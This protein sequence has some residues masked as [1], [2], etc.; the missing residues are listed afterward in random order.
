[1]RCRAV[2]HRLHAFPQLV[3]KAPDNYEFLRVQIDNKEV[4]SYLSHING[5]LTDIIEVTVED[6][7]Y[8]NAIKP[9]ETLKSQAITLTTISAVAGVA[10]SVLF[11]YLFISRQRETAQI[12]MMMG[13]GRPK[14]VS[15]LLYGILLVALIAT[16]VGSLIAG[17]FDVRVTDTVWQALQDAPGLDER[18]SERALGI[19]TTFVPE[20]ATAAWVRWSSAGALILIILIITI[21]FALTTLRKPKRKKIKEF[22]APKLHVGKGMAFVNMPTVSLRFAL[23]SIRRNF[24]RS[25][26]VPVTA[27]LLAAFIMAL[28]L[29]T[30]QQE[31]D[32]VTVYDDVPTTAYMTT[33]MGYSREVPLQLQANIFRLLDRIIQPEM[34]GL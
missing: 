7:G 25:L 15:Y 32:A 10:V 18:Y 8:T 5:Y 14:T 20:I 16:I 13:T 33:F 9:I 23:R 4:E 34:P 3:D 29:I 17:A 26:I 30:H 27:F 11:S 19:P 1:M 2:L 21:I 22:K 12:M 6:Q 28:G 31:L 24:L